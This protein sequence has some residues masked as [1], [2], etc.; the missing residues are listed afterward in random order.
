[1]VNYSTFE[2]Q[3]SLIL[4][5]IGSCNTTKS[6]SPSQP[7]YVCRID[8]IDSCP[9]DYDVQVAYGYNETFVSDYSE[10][11]HLYGTNECEYGCVCQRGRGKG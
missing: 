5:D 2:G 7:S 9:V 10:S 4:L 6:S 11:V 3:S 1:M 8:T